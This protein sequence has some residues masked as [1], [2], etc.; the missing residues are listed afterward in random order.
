[1]E[2]ETQ[3]SAPRTDDPPRTFRLDKRVSPETVAE[4]VAA[5]VGGTPTPELCKRYNI[6]EGGILKLLKEQ[7]VAMRR[8]GLSASQIDQAVRLYADGNS[9]RAIS[10]QLGSSSSTVRDAL[11][12]RGVTMRPARK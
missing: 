2:A 5:Y 6:S 9:L 10:A 12:A 8:Q 11:L 4:L 3:V 7:G 1:M